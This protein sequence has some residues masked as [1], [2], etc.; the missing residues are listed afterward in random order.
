MI[1][2]DPQKGIYTVG[3]NMGFPSV[4]YDSTD[5]WRNWEIPATL[6]YQRTNGKTVIHQRVGLK[7]HGGGSRLLPQ[8]SFCVI[9]GKKYGQENIQHPL[10]EER[11]T[12]SF[13]EVLLRNSGQDCNELHFKDVFV[14]SAVDSGTFNHVMAGQP[15]ILYLNNQYWGIYHLREKINSDYLKE[16]IGADPATVQLLEDIHQKAFAIE[17]KTQEFTALASFVANNDMSKYENY[18]QVDSALDIKNFVD[19]FITYIYFQNVDW[20]TNNAKFGKAQNGKWKYFLIDMDKAAV[21]ASENTLQRT[22][23]Y[24]CNMHVDVL[25][26]LLQNSEFKNYFVKRFLSINRNYLSA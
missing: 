19:Y 20:P 21:S 13:T 15:V 6:E 18:Q 4:E 23:G 11:N 7:I 5:F 22:L 17:G 8:K 25:N 3:T 2:F 26:S 12:D 1:F 16:K 9:A 24:K 14:H 10:F